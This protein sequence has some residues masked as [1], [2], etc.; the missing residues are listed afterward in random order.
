VGIPELGWWID[1]RKT[2]RRVLI[3]PK[4][5][6]SIIRRNWCRVRDFH[7]LSAGLVRR[8]KL[9]F[10]KHTLQPGNGRNLTIIDGGGT[11]NDP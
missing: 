9:L 5:H 4:L 8:P 2:L 11:H 1:E 10:G 3:N 7:E 6:Y